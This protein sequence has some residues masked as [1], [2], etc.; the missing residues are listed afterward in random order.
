MYSTGRE[1]MKRGEGTHRVSHAGD[2]RFDSPALEGAV[3][4]SRHKSSLP[5]ARVPDYEDLINKGCFSHAKQPSI[6]SRLLSLQWLM[7]QR[8]VKFIFKHRRAAQ[9][10]G[11]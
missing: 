1:G 2:H 10:G 3:R 8:T 6:D 9:N 7:V 5:Y 4:Q 11:Q